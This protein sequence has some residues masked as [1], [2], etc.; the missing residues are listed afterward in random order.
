[1]NNSTG[2]TT[3][4]HP[5]PQK[6]G[7]W[8][9]FLRMRTGIFYMIVGATAWYWLLSGHTS[10]SKTQ[11]FWAIVLLYMFVSPGIQIMIDNLTSPSSPSR[12]HV[13]SSRSEPWPQENALDSLPPALPAPELPP[14]DRPESP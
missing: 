7:K 9:T 4:I 5:A 10:F 1:M 2:S 12:Q 6:R 14:K 3:P 13:L 11:W 8:A